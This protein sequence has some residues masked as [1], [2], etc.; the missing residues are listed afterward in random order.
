MGKNTVK[1]QGQRSIG[2]A[3][4]TKRKKV[5]QKRKRRHQDR[6]QVSDFQVGVR[7]RSMDIVLGAHGDLQNIDVGPTLRG[8]KGKMNYPAQ[9]NQGKNTMG[10][11]LVTLGVV[12][13][14]KMVPDLKS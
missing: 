12:T 6:N 9:R 1:L 5:K 7:E 13:K 10:L 2:V 11:S 4:N 14:R 8:W 3:I